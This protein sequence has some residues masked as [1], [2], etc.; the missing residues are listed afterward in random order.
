MLNISF[1]ACTK[2]ELYDLTVCTAVNGEKFRSGAV[3]LTLKVIFIYMYYSVFKFHVLGSISFLN[4]RAKTHTETRKLTWT[5]T[6]TR[7][8]PRTTYCVLNA[9]NCSNV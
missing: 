3:T 8:D 4:Y 5:H 6:Q 2:V 9:A 7:T 1:L